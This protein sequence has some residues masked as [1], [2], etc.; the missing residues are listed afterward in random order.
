M[1]NWL[2]KKKSVPVPTPRP[3]ITP[4]VKNNKN[5]PVYEMTTSAKGLAHIKA[6]EGSKNNAYLDG[7]GVWTIGV[8]HTAAAGA[9][10]PK[11]GMVIT[12]KEILEILARDLKDV[13]RDVKRYVKV[14]LTQAQFDMLVS[15]VFNVGGGAFA[16]S[17]LLKLLNQGRY[18]D[19]PDQLMRWVNDN[20]KRVQG[21]VNRRSD[22][23]K[24]FQDGY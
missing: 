4:I 2:F 15:F 8:G 24:K 12:D 19:V 22:E 3:V 23:A 11:R 7:G 14:P 18:D 9:P 16:S 6:W 13:E 21:L 10:T 5:S 17:T 20:G 1:F